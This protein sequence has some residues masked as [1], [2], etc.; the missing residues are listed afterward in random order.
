MF[1]E[2]TTFQ[3][4]HTG[5]TE[6]HEKKSGLTQ[7]ERLVL[8][9]IDGV[10]PFSG[11]RA[12]LPVLTEDRFARAVQTLLNKDLILEVIL[13]VEGQAPE[14]VERTIIDRFLQQD[15]LDPVTIMYREDDERFAG[16]IPTQQK[17]AGAASAARVEQAPDVQPYHNRVPAPNLLDDRDEEA[18]EEIGAAAR[19]KALEHPLNSIQFIPRRVEKSPTGAKAE[20][21]G[22]QYWMLAVIGA[23]IL[24]YAFARLSI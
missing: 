22:W 18:A 24:G 5:R 19:A 4:T 13:P 9:M 10:T 23:F 14:L 21:T 20:A 7:S 15:P 6:I 8:I 12:K 17:T 16:Y 2:T 11:V 3:R 1:S